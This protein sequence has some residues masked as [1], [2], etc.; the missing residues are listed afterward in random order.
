MPVYVEPD[1]GKEP[2]LRF[3]RSSRRFL[4]M[5]F[6]LIDDS[7]VL[8]AVSD[9]IKRGAQVRIIYDGRPYGDSDVT[10][11]V[12]ALNMSGAKV[13]RSPAA[14]D[15]PGVFDHA[16]YMVNERQALIGT[17]NMTAAAFGRNREFIYITKDRA[18]RKSLISLFN[19]DWD[20]KETPRVTPKI[21]TSPGSETSVSSLVSR[22]IIAESEEIGDSKPVM[23]AFR[24]R[25]RHVRLVLPSTIS[26]SDRKN[27]ELLRESHVHVRLMDAKKLYMHAKAIVGRDF[28]FIG[29][30]NFTSTSLQKN[31][32]V[33]VILRGFFERRKVRR[34]VLHDYSEAQKA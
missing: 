26:A 25:G 22:A 13:R 2:V 32:E 28:A 16:K 34:T 17:A 5:N 11:E 3:I 6:Y 19:S 24:K 30:Q 15:R 14:F 21:I 20:G 33:G 10:A 8:K 29:S 23:E 9:T 12:K 1:D 27:A 4:L 31:R 7:D 18:I